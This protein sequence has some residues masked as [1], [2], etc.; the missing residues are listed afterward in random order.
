M[1]CGIVPTGDV[2][3]VAYDVTDGTGNDAAKVVWDSKPQTIEV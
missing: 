1:L 2:V 3:H